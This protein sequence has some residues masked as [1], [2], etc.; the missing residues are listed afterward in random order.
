MKQRP[1]IKESAPPSG[2]ALKISHGTAAIVSFVL[3]AA[4]YIITLLS[5]YPNLPIIERL[6][7]DIPGFD[8][9]YPP[10]RVD[11]NIYYSISQNILSGTLYKGEHSPER[12]FTLGFPLVAAPFIA[13]LGKMGGYAANLMIVLLSLGVFYLILYRYGFRRKA[14]V[15]TAIMA[16]ASLNWF[17]AVSN[18]T[19]PLS[20][21]L[22]LVSFALLLRDRSS[23]GGRTMIILSGVFTA[24]N[25]FV[26]PNYLLLA[27]PFFFYLGIEK[28]E[29]VSFDK[30]ALLYAGGVI[31]VIVVWAIRNT[32]V[33]GSPFTF[34]YTRLVSSFTPGMTSSQ[35]MQGNIFL[36][37]H[38]LLF[39]EYHG[40]LTITPI[41]LLFPAGLRAMWHKGM[42]KESLLLLA[43][44][45]I[46]VL[47][48]AAGPYPFTEFGLGSRHLVPLM[49]LLL[50]PAAFFLDG[51]LFTRSVVFLLALYSFYQAGIGWFTGGEPGM[52]F[53]LGILNESQ[54][55][56]IIL[57]RKELLPHR[58]FRSQEELVKFYTR[59]LK[60][61]DLMELLQTL[62]PL[63]I[64][65]IRGNERTFML[66]LRN[67][68]DPVSCILAADPERGIII[69]SFSISGGVSEG[70]PAP[71][72]SSAGIK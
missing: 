24:L 32:L 67:Q 52:G 40:L 31:A 43:G 15:M 50:L 36:G 65:K 34:E 13:V 22:V 20:Q 60:K 12:G 70:S 61:A 63:V 19:E 53:F 16:F 51:K 69:K 10:F 47:F 29:K 4:V 59:A 9:S 27:V 68:P 45:V 26:R 49:P 3:I 58:N 39:D 37:I 57:A 48:V 38:R 5:L 46:M 8:Q 54:S 64:E 55:R 18:Y 72:D 41:F 35:Y 1:K 2:S 17:Y 23:P 30:S 66:F 44:A 62:D 7:E 42:Q 33:F 21:L 71:P 6:A 25:L 14:L 28:K 56:A 11:E